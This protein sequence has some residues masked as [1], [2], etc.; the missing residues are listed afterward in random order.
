[1]TKKNYNAKGSFTTRDLPLLKGTCNYTKTAISVWCPFCRKFHVYEWNIEWETEE[2]K[3]EGKWTSTKCLQRSRAKKLNLYAMYGFQ[4]VPFTE[5]EL[6]EI[7]DF[8]EE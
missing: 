1:M 4:L 5:T 3:R 8:Q 2:V 7:H 6:R